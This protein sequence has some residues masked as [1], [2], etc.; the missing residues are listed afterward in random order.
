MRV[1]ILYLCKFLKTSFLHYILQT[2]SSYIF[3]NLPV[4][5]AI[6]ADFVIIHGSELPCS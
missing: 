5:P 2:M 3:I 6:R 1:L 4:Y